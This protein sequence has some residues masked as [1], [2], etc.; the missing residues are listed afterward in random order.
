MRLPADSPYAGGVF[1]L[2]VK[3]PLDYPFKPPKVSSVI[4]WTHFVARATSCCR[5]ELFLA[6]GHH[7]K[8]CSS[9]GVA[10]DEKRSYRSHLEHESTIATLA[11]TEIFAWTY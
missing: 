3:F 11:K 7:A 10:S 4:F 2:D 5:D 9:V 8:F 6:D 1:F